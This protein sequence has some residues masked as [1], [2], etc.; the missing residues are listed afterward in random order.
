MR[1]ILYEGYFSI[2]WL[3]LVHI[4]PIFCRTLFLQMTCGLFMSTVYLMFS[5]LLLEINT[6]LS[7]GNA[8]NKNDSIFIFNSADETRNMSSMAN[9]VFKLN[10]CRFSNMANNLNT[11]FEI[12]SMAP[13]F[14]S[15][16]L[17]CLFIWIGFLM[18][19]MDSILSSDLF[20]TG[21]FALTFFDWYFCY[22]IVKFI[23][24]KPRLCWLIFN[25]LKTYPIGLI[26]NNKNG[27]D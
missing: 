15:C 18:A 10:F 6:C 8:S 9:P 19:G 14:E 21:S 22:V 13:L 7:L 26:L 16:L 4:K 5:T 11:R 2:Y 12:Q 20:E 24:R 25:S 23:V 27:S 3:V 17:H 1:R